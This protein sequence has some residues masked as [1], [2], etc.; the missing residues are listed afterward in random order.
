MATPCLNTVHD[1]MYTQTKLKTDSCSSKL[2]NSCVPLSN[3]ELTDIWSQ[4]WLPSS[5]SILSLLPSFAVFIRPSLSSTAKHFSFLWCFGYRWGL[6]GYRSVS[7]SHTVTGRAQNMLLICLPQKADTESK[8]L[9]CQK[10][11]KDI[12]G[13][14]FCTPPISH[15]N[16]PST[17][18]VYVCIFQALHFPERS[19]GFM[20]AW[21]AASDISREGWVFP[22]NIW[23][24]R[25][26]R[27][28]SL[29]VWVDS[30]HRNT[31]Q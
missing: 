2:S 31:I 19:T 21:A 27:H 15:T 10:G 6:P 9:N 1:R 8:P 26:K 7:V 14:L 4:R 25:G 22:A 20:S 18:C 29:C 24:G 23:V 13:K 16:H 30:F 11:C 12:L 17:K 28:C 5:T 3:R